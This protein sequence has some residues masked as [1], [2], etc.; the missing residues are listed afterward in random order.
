[1]SILSYAGNLKT[2]GN[3]GALK[4]NA[5]ASIEFDF[6]QT[7]WENDESFKEYCNDGTYDERIKVSTLSFIN[8]FNQNSKGLKLSDDVQD[9]QYKVILRVYNFEQKQSGFGWGRF[10]IKVYG[11]ILVQD[12]KTNETIL[13]VVVKGIS[14][15]ADYVQTDRFKKSFTVLGEE[16]TKL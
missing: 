15:N 8:A 9:V 12:A 10:Y 6:S 4:Q 14:G 11:E 1:M 13:T 16:I 3:T 5:V 2:N 7:T